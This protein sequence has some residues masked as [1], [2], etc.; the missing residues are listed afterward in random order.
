MLLWRQFLETIGLCWV[1]IFIFNNFILNAHMQCSGAEIA[2]CYSV[3][4]QIIMTSVSHT[5]ILN[6][7]VTQRKPGEI[8]T[9]KFCVTGEEQRKMDFL[10]FKYKRKRQLPL[11]SLSKGGSEH[12][13]LGD[14][15]KKILGLYSNLFGNK[16]IF[17]RTSYVSNF[18]DLEMSPR[19]LFFH[20]M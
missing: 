10:F 9:C 20:E 17:V 16:F 18:H 13:A 12:F 6:P 11:L 5:L 14:K 2:C 1:L 8:Y 7:G 19:S 4:K 15:M 3:K